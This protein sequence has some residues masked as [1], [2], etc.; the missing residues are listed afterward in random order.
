M[1][2]VLIFVGALSGAA[3]IKISLR[4][5][6]GDADGAKQAGYVAIALCMA[7]LVLFAIVASLFPRAFGRIFTNDKDFLD[8]WEECW[9][10]FLATLTLMNLSVAIER[11]PYSM[12]RTVAVFRMA[13]IGSWLGKSPLNIVAID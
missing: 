9:Y 5:G 4:L 12:G 8:L 7:F 13:L 11:I 3:G 2:T 6:N 10:P 1:W